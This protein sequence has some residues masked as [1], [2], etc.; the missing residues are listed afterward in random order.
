M[1]SRL[2]AILFIFCAGCYF[3]MIGCATINSMVSPECITYIQENWEHARIVGFRRIPAGMQFKLKR[4]VILTILDPTKYVE[5]AI[6]PETVCTVNGTSMNLYIE[7][8]E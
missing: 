3:W 6:S 8:P 2:F 4:G 7:E 5:R 1:F